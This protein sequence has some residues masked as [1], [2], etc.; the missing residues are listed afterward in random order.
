MT[1]HGPAPF[2]ETVSQLDTSAPPE[3]VATF[4]F[5]LLHLDGDDLLDTPLEE[6][7]ARLGEVAP[8]LRVPSVV[9]S[10]P[11]TAERVLTD[12]IDAGH[13]GVVVKDARSLYSAGRRG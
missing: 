9:T 10:D 11:A 4:L 3:R 2:Q 7:I 12:A 1:D 6:R 5:D 13:E 8:S